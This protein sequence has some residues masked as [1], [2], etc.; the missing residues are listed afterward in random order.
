MSTRPSLALITTSYPIKNDG[1]EAAGVFVADLAAALSEWLDVRVIAPGSIN[2]I[3]DRGEAIEIY[4]Y[5]TPDFPLST[6]KVWRPDHQ[7][8]IVKVQKSGQRAL[9]A[10]VGYGRVDHILALWALPS[11]HW[12]RRTSLRTGIPYSVWTLGSDIWGLGRIPILRGY[13]AK[14]LRDAIH[15]YSDGYQ[16]ADDTEKIAK[17]NV[18]FLPSTR[19]FSSDE[20]K[21]M[22]TQPPY[23][24]LFLGRWHINKGIDILIDALKQLDESSWQRIER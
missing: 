15:C 21:S 4:R 5:S 17:R 7:I 12:A 6:L 1:S 11:G 14:V 23:R 8:A 18:N 19:Q 20:M 9:D 3:E 10:A 13:L 16:L 22:R 2:T 24:L